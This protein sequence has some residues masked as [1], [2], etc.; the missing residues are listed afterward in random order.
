MTDNPEMAMTAGAPLRQKIVLV[1]AATA[2]TQQLVSALSEGQLEVLVFE[3]SEAALAAIQAEPPRL[4][5]TEVWSEEIDGLSLLKALRATAATRSL[6]VILT[7]RQTELEERLKLM[8]LEI[9]DFIAKPYYP[10]EVVA[11]VESILQESSLG[12]EEQIRISQGFAGNL[13]EMNL[14]DLIQT[15]ELGKKSAV[16]HLFR[17]PDEGYIFMAQGEV[18]DAVLHELPPLEALDNLLMWMDGYFELSMQPVTRRRQ[19]H[20]SNRE[21][22][23][24]GSQRLHEYRERTS[25]LPA[26]NSFIAR[27]AEIREPALTN[28][29][30]RIWALLERPQPIRLVI[31]AIHGDELRTLEAIQALSDGHYII[32]YPGADSETDL[33][34]S[35][36]EQRMAAT[37]NNGG[38]PYERAAS[39]FTGS[40]QKKNSF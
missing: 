5:I 35:D 30:L 2:A 8:G 34:A 36:L 28:L 12:Q 38:D 15:L 19:I 14:M 9:D 24:S 31:S 25:H 21:V 40:G 6:P 27:S 16:I 26:L 37:R 10:E 4:V 11:R 7:T 33:V 1:D 3:Q 22:L 32:N 13:E 18:I 39:F 20:R 17:D 29:E 23:L